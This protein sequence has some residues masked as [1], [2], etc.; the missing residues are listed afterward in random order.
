MKQEM[1]KTAE[2][3]EKSERP[4]VKQETEMLVR[5]LQTDIPGSKNLFSGLSRI[6]G[7][8]FSVVNSVCKN[9]GIDKKRKI[10]SLSP[11]EID[12]LSKEIKNPQIPYFNK[13][14]R[15]DFETGETK[16]L[17]TTELD[18]KKEFDIKRLKKIKTYKGIRHSRGLPVRGQRTKSHFRKRTKNKVV[19][20]SKKSVGKKG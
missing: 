9:T 6:K 15:Y 2:N 11:Q 1:D 13:N 16:H 10:S 12:K 14:R 8:S 7:V 4:K 19:G 5:I 3:K 18:L 17:V 20:V